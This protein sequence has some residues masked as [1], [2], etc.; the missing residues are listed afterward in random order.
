[1]LKKILV[2]GMLFIVSNVHAS[3]YLINLGDGVTINKIHAHNGGGV[4]LW[5]DGSKLSNPDGC[6]NMN[7]VHLPSSTA[8]IA[9]QTSIVLSAYMA[10]KKIGMW[11]TG[12]NVIPFWGGTTRYPIVTEV[13]ITE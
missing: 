7:K 5:V 6:Q 12:C 9:A 13:W 8:G 3:G 10:G 1:M 4:T 2:I 11:S